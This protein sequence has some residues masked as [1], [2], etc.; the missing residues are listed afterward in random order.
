[1]VRNCQ[2]LTLEDKVSSMDMVEIVFIFCGLVEY[3]WKLKT[4]WKVVNKLI[5]KCAT[6]VCCF[7]KLL[8]DGISCFEI[9]S[10]MNSW[11]IM[12]HNLQ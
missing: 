6:V 1:M 7:Q 8:S 4:F 11:K 3:D 9:V 2:L 12:M 5:V 10:V